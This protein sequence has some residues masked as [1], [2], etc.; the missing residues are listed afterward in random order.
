MGITPVP[1]L[2]GVC[3]EIFDFHFSNPSGPLINKM[4]PGNF[5]HVSWDPL[6]ILCHVTWD[7]LSCY[8]GS[9]VMLPGILCHNTWYPLSFYL[10]SFVMLPG[11]GTALFYV[12][13]ASFFCV[14]LKHTT[15]FF[16]EFLATYETQKYDK[17]F[18][19]LFLRT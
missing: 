9:F 2:K 7:P 4:L 14:L 17:F 16:S 12:L 15:S 6:R 1:M 10:G 8:L 18:C 5:C 3:H 11:L 19:I 13:N